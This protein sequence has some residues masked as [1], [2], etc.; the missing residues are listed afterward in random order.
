MEW[1]VKKAD[2]LD[3]LSYVGATDI[4]LNLYQVPDSKWKEISIWMPPV[5]IS[6]KNSLA[7]GEIRVSY[8]RM[9]HA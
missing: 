1:G 5:R 9:V 6:E 7:A 3:L 8:P 2:E 4:G